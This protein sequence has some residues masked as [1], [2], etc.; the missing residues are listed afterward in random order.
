MCRHGEKKT[1]LGCLDGKFIGNLFVLKRKKSQ[2]KEFEHNIY[3]FANLSFF[4]LG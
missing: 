2:N 4:F 3:V 1:Y